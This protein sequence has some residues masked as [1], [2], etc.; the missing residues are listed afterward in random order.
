[1][2]DLKQLPTPADIT[3]V[4]GDPFTITFTATSGV[5]TFASPAV[6]MT[7]SGGDAYTTD[8]GVPSVSAVGAVITVTWSAADTAAL[9]ATTRGRTYKYST[10]ATLDGA[11][12]VQLFGGTITVVPVGTTGTSTSSSASATINTGGVAISATI[13]IGAQGPAGAAGA[14]GPPGDDGA[15]GPP[16]DDGAQ[17][18]AG[19]THVVIPFSHA[20]NAVVGSGTMRYYV[21]QTWTISTVRASVNVAP[22]GA[23]LIVDVNK[24]GTTIFTTQGNRPQ[25]AVSTNTDV[26]GA[27]DVTSLTSGDYLTVDID[28][29]GSTIAGSDLVVTIT[30]TA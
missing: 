13:N 11:G 24:N 29:I 18:P 8:P 23:A 15:Q 25:I 21:D 17:G 16:G 9:N 19:A 5:T 27:P 30:L 26:S 10:E 1:M 6:A 14:Q 7:T 2:A 28:Q 4:A 3:V 22:T 20:G 12:P